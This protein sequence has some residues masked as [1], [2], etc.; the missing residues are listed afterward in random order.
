MRG[1]VIGIVVVLV[2]LFGSFGIVSG[3][4]NNDGSDWKYYDN[5]TI[6]EN[7]GDRLR[8]YQVLVGLDS[9]NFD[10]SLARSDGRDIRFYDEDDD[11]LD[12]WIEEF[13]PYHETAKIWVKVTDIPAGNEIKIRMYYGNKNADSRSDGDKTFDFFDDFEEEDLNSAKWDSNAGNVVSIDDGILYM[14]GDWDFHQ[15]FLSTDE[16]FRT[17]VVVEARARLSCYQCGSDLEI[18]FVQYKDDHHR[19]N[20]AI[21]AGFDH[22]DDP[23]SKYI[24]YKGNSILSSKQDLR[25]NDWF[26][27]KITYTDDKVRLWDSFTEG[28][29]TCNNDM[30]N[31]F[32]LALAG[33]TDNQIGRAHV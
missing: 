31:P 25:T 29:Q 3:L 14:T 1:N 28:T 20:D 9:D 8:D 24:F 17:P 5:I 21:F 27:I 32:Y 33:D 10:F 2:L 30:N 22:D 6:E 12:Y 26:N 4:P 11:E 7:S 23:R 13:D 19:N 15:Y 16:R 18:G